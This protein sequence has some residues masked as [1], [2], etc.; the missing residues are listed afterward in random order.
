[1]NRQELLEL[2]QRGRELEKK[3]QLDGPQTD[4]ELHKW[5]VDTLG[6]DIPRTSVC[7]GHSAP[8]TFFADLYFE[9]TGSAILVANRGGSKTFLVAILHYANSTFKP[10]CE[11]LTIGA[12]ENQAK[13][14]YVH[15]K[16]FAY[17]KDT[18]ELRPEVNTPKQM[19]TLFKNGSKLE[20]LPGTINSVNGPHSQKVHFDEVELADPV[21]YEES[22]NIST[23]K[24]T[25]DGLLIRAQ[26]ILTS[27]RKRGKGLMQQ[28]LD[29]CNKSM[30][31]GARPPFIPYF[32]CVFETAE[33]VKNCQVACPDLPEGERCECD[34][35]IKG[36]W[37]A[38]GTQQRTLKSICKGKFYKS[39]G[40]QPI[41]DI[42]NTFMQSSRSV[43]EA[44]QECTK[45][46]TE[47]MYIPHF[48]RDI[49]GLVNFQPDPANGPISMG[50]DF[51]GTNP[52]AV[53]WY[54][55]LRYEVEAMQSNGNIIRLKEGTR[56]CFDEIYI[57]EIGN[58]KLAEKIVNKEEGWRRKF[59]NFR[60]MYRFADPQAKA[61]RLDFKHHNPP[62]KCSW[63]TTREFEEHVKIV[64][65]LFEDNLMFVDVKRCPMFCEEIEDWRRDKNDRQVDTFNHCMSEFRY[66]M[67]NLAIVEKSK[68]KPRSL[69]ASTG[70]TTTRNNYGPDPTVPASSGRV[71]SA[72]PQSERWRGKLGYPIG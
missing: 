44:Q 15:F 50:V 58:V 56:V 53:N 62:L 45:P 3:L 12:I 34:K 68:L 52:H 8:F 17:D 1:M 25:S 7:E 55:L 20:I 14:A 24:E 27:T 67:A 39:R 41:D 71:S 63:F 46:E 38:E 49:H 6:I 60:V 37:D 19:E 54:Q 64:K 66:V 31:A 11:S 70:K 48:S 42:A 33:Q 57:T 16:K 30:E 72:Y 65:E 51:G 13:R 4:D 2:V 26:D 10:G 69:P 29:V 23:S 59:P 36:T 9:R 43:W 40:W 28:I 61:A 21:V 47:D 32:W 35:I 22:R 18:G 5:V